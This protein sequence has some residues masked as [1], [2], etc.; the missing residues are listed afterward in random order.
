MK[1]LVYILTGEYED[2]YGVIEHQEGDLVYIAVVL[3]ENKNNV[4]SVLIKEK[5]SNI[6]PKTYVSSTQEINDFAFHQYKKLEILND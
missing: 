5:I 3:K 6:E 4:G 2:H 1:L